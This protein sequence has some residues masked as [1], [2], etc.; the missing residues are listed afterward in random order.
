[1]VC[2]APHL[3]LSFLKFRLSALKYLPV[4]LFLILTS[5]IHYGLERFITS[6]SLSA[7]RFLRCEFYPR[8]VRRSPGSDASKTSLSS[9]SLN[10]CGIE[11]GLT[12]IL[13]VPSCL[14]SHTTAFKTRDT[15]RII[16]FEIQLLFT[17]SLPLLQRLLRCLIP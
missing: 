1:M 5:L 13:S 8:R 7:N 6:N 4:Y 12:L 16:T 3:W 11:G 14:F 9:I 17:I 10:H 2:L 15:L